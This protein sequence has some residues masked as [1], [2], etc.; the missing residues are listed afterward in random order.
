[1][2]EAGYDDPMIARVGSL[3]CKENLKSDAET[4]TLEDVICLVFLESYFADFAAKHAHEPE[5]LITILRRTWRKMSPR[6][7]GE[8][9]KLPL[10]DREKQLIQR[11]L[12]PAA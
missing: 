12:N 11:A 4:Q 10:G 3:L 7:Q 6:G 9:L 1:M 8:A 5:K 2:R